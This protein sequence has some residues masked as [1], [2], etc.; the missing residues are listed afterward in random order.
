MADSK[1]TTPKLPTRSMEELIADQEADRKKLALFEI[2]WKKDG[3]KKRSS[4]E[5]VERKQK[6]LNDL[7]VRIRDRYVQLM[8]GGF[9]GTEDEHIF[10]EME[11][12]KEA[13]AQILEQAWEKSTVEPQAEQQE[14]A[15]TDKLRVARKKSLLYL[16]MAL[17]AC[18]DCSSSTDLTAKKAEANKNYLLECLRQFSS[19]HE[20][21]LERYAGDPREMARE[22][23]QLNIQVN[24]LADDLRHLAGVK[25]EIR[26]PAIPQSSMASDPYLPDV[27]RQQT[28]PRESVSDPFQELLSRLVD[29]VKDLR[30]EPRSD[31]RLPSIEIPKFSGKPGGC[32]EWM[33]FHDLFSAMVDKKPLDNIIKMTLLKNHVVGDAA[34]TIAHYSITG[35]NYQSAWDDLCRTYHNKKSLIMVLLKKLFDVKVID[36]DSSRELKLLLD[37]F[38]NILHSLQNLDEP[39]KQWNSIVVFM[40]TQRLPVNTLSL[41]EQSCENSRD[42]PLLANLEKF[43]ES[44][45]AALH[46]VEMRGSTSTKVDPVRRSVPKANDV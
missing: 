44:R 12:Q 42:V 19:A 37:T 14:D 3:P 10:E 24:E 38:K 34:S 11:L 41:W 27:P 6:A 16:S 4:R 17:E 20:K 40:M 45:I 1:A 2:N 22:F 43:L 15:E 23:V 31:I 18:A 30:K 7:W 33:E 28:K 39:V 36:S 35:D 29:E 5:F 32:D 21:Y 8:E 25:S 46:A 26:A 9:Q 13:M